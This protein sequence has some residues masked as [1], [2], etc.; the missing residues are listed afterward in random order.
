M[1]TETT[2]TGNDLNLWPFT[3]QAEKDEYEA[4]KLDGYALLRQA[5]ELFMAAA[6]KRE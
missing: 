6:A 3:S 1:T 2:E 4:L 5:H